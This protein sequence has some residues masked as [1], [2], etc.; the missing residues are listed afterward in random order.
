[1]A[2]P[3]IHTSNLIYLGISALGIAA[4]LMVG[5]FPNA[6]A[7]SQLDGS[8]AELNLKI[9]SQELLYPIY[10]E[11]IKEVQQKVPQELILPDGD[12]ITRNDFDQIDE[13][14]IKLAQENSVRFE[15]AAPDASSYLEEAG[16]LT[17]N[18]NFSGDFFDF[19][20]LVLGICQ[21]A[22]LESIEEMRVETV[23]EKK[24]ITFKLKLMQE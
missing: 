3:K 21:M 10:R 1:M 12:K 24:I 15:S 2:L 22:Y 14:F 9:Q 8:I 16:H 4:F 17:M 20:Q 18:V 23:D 19:R 5:I 6:I 11:L 7:L 13:I